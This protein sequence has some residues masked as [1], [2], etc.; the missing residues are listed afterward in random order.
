[1]ADD[2]GEALD[3]LVG[4]GQFA[5]AFPNLVLETGVGGVQRFSGRLHLQHIAPH[6][7]GRDCGHDQHQHR[8]QRVDDD[9]DQPEPL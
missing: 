3:F 5:G 9:G 8:R 7:P 4:A 1:M 2:I 6:Q